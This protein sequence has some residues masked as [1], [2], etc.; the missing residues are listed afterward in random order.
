MSEM[1]MEDDFED[2]R[3]Y[4][5]Y[6]INPALKRIIS[7]PAFDKILDFLFSGQDKSQIK[8]KL[9]DTFSIDDFQLSFMHP[10]V[11][12]ILN[13]T[14]KGLTYDGFEQLTPGTPYLFM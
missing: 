3:P 12:S 4:F 10:L 14:S 1:I 13:K 6:E 8:Q 11:H 9:A 7:D 2:I 5:D